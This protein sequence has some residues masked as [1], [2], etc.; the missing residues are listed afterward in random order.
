MAGFK[1]AADQW[2]RAALEGI[3]ESIAV[4]S[5]KF[6]MKGRAFDGSDR[7][8]KVAAGLTA[9]QHVFDDQFRALTDRRRLSDRFKR[10]WRNLM[11]YAVTL[12]ALL[13]L[14]VLGACSAEQSPA[15]SEPNE[16]TSTTNPGDFA[17]LIDAGI[18]AVVRANGNGSSS[19]A[20]MEGII[21]NSSSR[22]VH[23]DIIMSRPVF[24]RNGGRG[25]NMIASMIL[26]GDNSYSQSRGNS[27]VSLR[28]NEQSGVKF[29]AYCADFEKDNPTP[30]ETFTVDTA[31]PHLVN[32]MRRVA[33][34]ARANPDAD[35]TVPAQVAVWLAQGVNSAEIAK[36]F[37]F[38]AS[39]EVL[40][41]SFLQ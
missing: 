40:A 9:L 5:Y 20:S 4:E 10:G 1:N 27:F 23:V 29:I 15:S 33:A 35:F 14:L 31:P 39:D 30:S 36:R 16:R 6:E 19:G 13:A 3:R 7:L 28:P 34:H 26:N 21:Q 11:K 18:L 17:D 41:R 8:D 22:P 2:L 25:Q 12:S 24:F 37:P 32:V 38:T